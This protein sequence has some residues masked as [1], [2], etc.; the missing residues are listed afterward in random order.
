[1]EQNINNNGITVLENG[2]P[3]ENPFVRALNYE[4]PK[5]KIET[6][7]GNGNRPLSYISWS[8]AWGLFKQIYPDA[9]Y[10]FVK[11]PNTHM[12]YF[13]D[14]ETG[15]M[16]NVRVTANGET[17]EIWLFVMDQSNQAMRTVPYEY[18]KWNSRTGQ[19]ETKGVKAATTFD[20]NKTLM[21][22]LVKCL[23]M[24]GFG[25]SLYT[26]DDLPDFNL[27]T[28]ANSANPKKSSSR[29]GTK[30]QQPVAP[31][32]YDKYANIKNALASANSVDELL[33]LYK[34][35][36]AEVEGNPEIKQLF[37]QRKQQLNLLNAA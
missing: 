19:W 23:A 14:P 17:Q 35:H 12:P 8:Y 31:P 30:A 32:T 1:M 15:I 16:V 3:Q 37:T 20:I 25:L 24:F 18:Q 21:R 13:V 4:I 22:A 5:D 11:N 34:Q 6:I 7:N 2:N 9:T 27:V 36:Q 29:R 28:D 10:E 33:S 26:G